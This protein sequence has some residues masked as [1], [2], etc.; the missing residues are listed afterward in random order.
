VAEDEVTSTV[1]CSAA[2]AAVA[3]YSV[4]ALAGRPHFG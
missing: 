2:G 3:F 1:Q 4:C